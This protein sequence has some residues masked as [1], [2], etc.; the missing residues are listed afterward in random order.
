MLHRRFPN[1]PYIKQTTHH[2][3]IPHRILFCSIGPE[4]ELLMRIRNLLSLDQQS[5]IYLGELGLHLVLRHKFLDYGKFPDRN[6][7]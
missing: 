6:A 3:Q 7:P 4:H 1:H 5:N 2:G